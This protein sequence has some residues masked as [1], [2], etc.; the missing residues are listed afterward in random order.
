ML[1]M[2]DLLG[3]SRVPVGGGQFHPQ[4]GSCRPPNVCYVLACPED[5][6]CNPLVYFETASFVAQANLQFAI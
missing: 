4:M 6:L 5:G 3:R 1:V 2:G